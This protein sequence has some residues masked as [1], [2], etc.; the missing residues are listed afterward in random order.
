[1]ARIELVTCIAA[2]RARCFDLSRR[3]EVHVQSAGRSAER[4]IAGRTSGLLSLGEEVTWRARHFGVS[5][6]LTSRITAF[7]RPEYFQDSMV[8]GPLASLVHDHHFADDGAGGT[9]MRDAFSFRAPFSVFGRLAE[10]AFLTRHFRAFLEA[11]NR[12]I[13]RIAESDGLH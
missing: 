12:E 1:M 2:P 10:V 13:K 7:R 6:T 3:V 8:R 5:L 9:L 11:R 4:A